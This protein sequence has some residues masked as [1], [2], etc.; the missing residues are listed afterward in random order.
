MKYK[1]FNKNPKHKAGDC[2]VRALA[3]A[4]GKTWSEVY[5]ELCEI[6]R[7]AYY[8]PSDKEVYEI[9]LGKNDFIKHRQPRKADNRKYKVY[10]LVDELGIKDAVISLSGHMTAIEDGIL[11]DTWDCSYL[12][13]GNYWTKGE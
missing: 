7:E 4:A 13:V 1:N 11:Y 10:E 8:M 9:W 3:L 5:D 6:G 2:V 12:T